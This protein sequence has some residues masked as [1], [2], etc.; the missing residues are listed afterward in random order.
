[1]II[2]IILILAV[3]I[4]GF[5]LLMRRETRALTVTDYTVCSQR[6]PM[7]ADGTD[8]VVI[9]DLHNNQFGTDNEYLIQKIDEIHPDFIIIAGDL[10][11]AR[12]YTFDIA[13]DFLV[14]VSK[15]YPVYYSYGNHEQKVEEYENKL[16]D[17]WTIKKSAAREEDDTRQIKTFAQYIELVKRIGVHILD[18]EGVRYP[19]GNG[20]NLCVFGGTIGLEYFR[21]FH[22]P[23]MT[24]G[25][26]N[27]CFGQC[28]QNDYQILVAHN[29]MYFDAYA[30]WGA[31]LVLSGHV[32]GGMVRIP[33]LGGAISPQMQIFPRYD[34][35][36]FEKKVADHTTTMIVSRGL[37]IHTL[38]IRVFNRPELVH[39]R[40]KKK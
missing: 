37:G 8:F 25:Y 10:F 13:Y 24:C 20:K 38:K 11:V 33:F 9:A 6:L 39:V 32:H 15:K 4:L 16:A 31:D 40:L 14:K 28:N 7:E 26:L 23:E 29:P 18:N 2:Y 34:A 22:R 17:G 35:G 3:L 5:I 27:Q 36:L 12:D 1:M 21:R 19:V 30:D